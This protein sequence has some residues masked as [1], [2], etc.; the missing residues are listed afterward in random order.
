MGQFT[1]KPK[2]VDISEAGVRMRT[3]YLYYTD[4]ELKKFAPG[5][6]GLGRIQKEAVRVEAVAAVFD[7]SGFTKFCNQ[8]DPQLYVPKFM[9]EFLNW[10]FNA[11]KVKMVAMKHENGRLLW[12]E[13]PFF[14]K[15]MGDGV[16]FLWDTQRLNEVYLC[17]ILVSLRNTCLE[18]SR[19]FRVNLKGKFKSVPSKMRCGVARGTVYS[20]GNGK[21]FIGPCIN[22][23]SRLISYSNLM[24]SFS[25]I[26]FELKDGMVKETRDNYITKCA[27][28][29]GMG[30]EEEIICINKKD[31]DKLSD[32]EKKVFKDVL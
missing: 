22:L 16:I 6:L 24:F 12:S 17:N 29:R 20:I 11:V 28:I 23:A 7:L 8:R 21:D 31:F 30:Q 9:N 10:L 2:M 13:L 14:A 26:G 5:V 19:I 32:K 4:K 18:Y 25:P 3:L 15:F 27:Y 1:I